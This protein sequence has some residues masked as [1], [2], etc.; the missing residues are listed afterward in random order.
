MA[1][2]QHEHQPPMRPSDE[3]T[4]KQ[5]R[6]AKAQ[7]DAF[8]QALTAMITDEAHGSVRP[9]GDY[10]VG[11][12]VEQAE[13]MYHLHDGH[14]EWVAP[15]EENLHVEVVVCDAADGR[16]IPGLTVYATLID[17]TGNEIGTYHQPFLWHPWLYH[18]GRNWHVPG[19]G[20]YTL[21]IRVEAPEW[22]RHD[23]INGKRFA[24][25]VEVEFVK[26]G[27]TTGQKQS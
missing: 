21:R 9:V 7:G 20:I 17:S 5:L 22:G 27:I 24:E 11:Y 26:V 10:L 13:G 18:Y 19:D 3:A 16:F 2:H 4:E 14:L 23:K 15:E 8:G 12:A 1:Y 6:L 25:P